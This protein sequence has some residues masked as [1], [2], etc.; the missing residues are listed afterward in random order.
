LEANIKLIEM[1]FG[2][3][4]PYADAGKKVAWQIFNNEVE[5]ILTNNEG[6]E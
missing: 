1:V 2:L 6:K 5:T 3:D 4:N